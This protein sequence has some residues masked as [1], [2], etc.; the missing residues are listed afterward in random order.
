MTQ[1][2]AAD[3]LMHSLLAKSLQKYIVGH[4]HDEIILEVPD[5]LVGHYKEQLEQEM[6]CLPTW[7][8]GLPIA[9]EVWAGKR[10]KK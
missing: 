6:I 9:A 8:E 2:A 10:Y 4:I 5:H 3:I 7:A 1:A